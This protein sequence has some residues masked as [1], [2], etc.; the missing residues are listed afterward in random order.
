MYFIFHRFWLSVFLAGLAL[1][2]SLS[3]IAQ[4]APVQVPPQPNPNIDRFPQSP[5]MPQPLPTNEQ[6]PTLPNPPPTTPT[7][8]DPSVN[9]SVRKIE[10][11]GSTVFSN[12]EIATITK[13]LEGRSV[14]LAELQGTVDQ[15]SEMYLNRGYITSRAILTEQTINN[16]VVKI[17]VIEGGVEK[18][19]VLGIEKV[20]PS[21]VRSRLQLGTVSP[22][23]KDKLED[24][25]R[26]LKVDPLFSNV[27]AY[28]KQGTELGQSILTVRVEE[29][30]VFY[31]YVGIDNY[32]PPSVGSERF[33]GFISNRNL[34]GNGDE[35]TVSY[36]RST[37]GGSNAYDFRYRLPVNPMNGSIQLRVAP[38]YSRITEPQ[39]E[40]FGIR[41][42]TNLYEISYRQPLI[43]NPREEF[44]LSL[45]FAWQ[46]G[47]T[48]LF[49]D[50]PTPFGIGPDAEGNSRTRVLKFGQDYL[51]RDLQGA[52]ALRSQFNIGLNILDSTTNTDPIPD[53]QFFSWLTQLQRVQRLSK[54]NL[55]IAQL[56]LQLTPD[57][58]LP[59]QQF[60]I[61]GG[62]SLRGYRQNARSGDNG[63]RA[64]LEDRIVLDYNNSGQPTMQLAPF[65][66]VGAVWNKSDN[67]NKLTN[68]TFL[69]G[70]GV[71]L[72]W[73]PIPHLSGRLDYGLPLV[74]LSDRG[75]NAQD[76]GF[77]FSFGY[78]F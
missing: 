44:A 66:D 7:P 52:W 20:N 36:Y 8:A 9:I 69:V 3:A 37:T 27:E 47:Q 70:L 22:L 51:K 50:T 78:S 60:V 59:S 72:I 45:G 5:P 31:G 32:S 46:D 38:S 76:H 68:Q 55:L 29:A 30:P 16:G 75:N 65:I 56:D 54:D 23:S 74:D 28:L 17:Q 14:T 40:V 67:P 11:I 19:E 35:I 64:S 2:T 42:D 73:E 13:P 53:G 12:E 48:F 57:S 63:F 77:Y 4:T 15:I 6:Q 43:R 24:Q 58:L 39:F 34:T 1:F 25:L 10:V 49:N 71:G 21:Y 62:Q 41:S 26:L 33:G 18:I 61:G